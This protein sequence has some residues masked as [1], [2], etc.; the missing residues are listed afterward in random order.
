MSRVMHHA[1]AC[2][3]RSTAGWSAWTIACVS[4]LGCIAL[5]DSESVANLDAGPDNALDAAAANALEGRDGLVGGDALEGADALEGGELGS[6][7][8]GANPLS[9]TSIA[10]DRL[11]VWL[12]A[13]QG[14]T[15]VAG[16]LTKWKDQSGH[17][18][19]YA[20]L[21][22]GQ[23]GPQCD[24]PSHSYRDVM[25][26]YFSAP[27]TQNSYDETLD[28]DLN[29]LVGVEYTIFVVERRWA[30]YQDRSSSA[31]Y[32]IGTTVPGASR[33]YL[34]AGC[35]FGAFQ[36]GYAY[37]GNGPQLVLD[38]GC[39]RVAS[40]VTK[41]PAGGPALL[42]R[43]TGA[44]SGVWGQGLWIP[45][46]PPAHV[47]DQ[48]ML[49]T[50]YAGAIGRGIVSDSKSDTRFRGDIAEIVIYNTA[51]GTMDMK[52]VEAYLGAHWGF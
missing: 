27:R 38:Q 37:D 18:N 30:D 3:V 9:P 43:E 49:T 8:G 7:E 50:A 31:E 6:T 14:M 42:S 16:R 36:F 35:A 39:S 47:P 34:E 4:G 24:L 17:P 29:C 15:C 33:A 41:V 19:V 11:Q 21:L 22:N 23:L 26:P 46:A 28:I 1:F 51:L 25:L 48:T 52:N 44:Y 32:L 5:K 40:K 45:G 13:D 20:S 10:P 12:T 2:A